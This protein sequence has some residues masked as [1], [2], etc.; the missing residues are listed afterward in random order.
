MAEASQSYEGMSDEE[1]FLSDVKSYNINGQSVRIGSLDWMDEG[2]AEAFMDRMLDAMADVAED[3]EMLFAKVDVSG[4]GCYVLYSGEGAEQVA[5]KAFGTP[6]RRGVCY[7]S[8]K[9]N[10]KRQVVPMITEALERQ[11]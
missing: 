10:R 3:G 2:T 6:V 7:S 9:L 4:K 8:L 5:T 1:I 11:L